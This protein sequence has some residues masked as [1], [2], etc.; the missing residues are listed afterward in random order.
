MT[1]GICS[2]L[3]HQ[4]NGQ[5][6]QALPL[7]E[8]LQTK[9]ARHWFTAQ[10]SLPRVRR[11]VCMW[12]VATRTMQNGSGA[13]RERLRVAAYIWILLCYW[14]LLMP[15]SAGAQEQ[16]AAAQQLSL[17][18]ES[19]TLSSN[20]HDFVQV[21]DMVYFIATATETGSELWKTDGTAE[22]TVLVREYLTG[23]AKLRGVVP[24]GS[25]RYALFCCRRRTARA[26]VVAQRRH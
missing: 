26:R 21:G 4:R 20:P 16:P 23:T 22:G 2:P 13:A 3:E 15:A 6:F 5:S 19:G 9:P 17:S 1:Q 12:Y 10:V 24:H 8:L 11:K 7:E 25:C 14:M 18:P